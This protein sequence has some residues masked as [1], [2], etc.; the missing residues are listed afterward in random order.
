LLN[1]RNIPYRYREYTADPL[2]AD[3]VRDIL[4]R[5]DVEPAAVL[6]RNDKAY[7]ELG[8]TG[9][10]PPEVLI[11]YMAEHPTLLQRPIGLL[12]DRAVI[13]R[14]AENLLALFQEG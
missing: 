6:R 14:P 7:K 2:S 9:Q 12:G 3:E 8:L 11:G 5:L 13:G 4:G 10:E 1:E